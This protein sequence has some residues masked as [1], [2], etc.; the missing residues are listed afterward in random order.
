MLLRFPIH[1]TEERFDVRDQHLRINIVFALRLYRSRQLQQR[2]KLSS[3]R[4]EEDDIATVMLE[5]NLAFVV[6]LLLFLRRNRLCQKLF[7]N[8]SL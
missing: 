8:I 1:Q 3:A 7:H 6:H 5:S 4:H 2:S